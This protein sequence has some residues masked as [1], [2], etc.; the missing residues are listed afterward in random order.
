MN[1][2]VKQILSIAL[3]IILTVFSLLITVSA[4]TGDIYKYGNAYDVRRTPRFPKAGEEVTLEDFDLPI[5][6][7]KENGVNEDGQKEFTYT[8]AEETSGKWSLTS[9]GNYDPNKSYQENSAISVE[10]LVTTFAGRYRNLEGTGLDEDSEVSEFEK[11]RIEI[12][13]LKEDDNHICYGVITS[14]FDDDSILF[15]G[16]SYNEDSG[17]GYYLSNSSYEPTDKK[18]LM[19][20]FDLININKSNEGK[21]EEDKNTDNSSPETND[22]QNNNSS[23]E[24]NNK[25][26][27]NSTEPKETVDI[28]NPNTGDNSNAIFYISLMSISI[29]AFAGIII[30]RKKHS[31]R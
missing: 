9:V 4:K 30:Y 11:K 16:T 29:I 25:Q 28:Y 10:T 21:S 17:A 5:T 2:K 15:F 19:T 27:N 31:I 13:E 12:F 14:Y 3:C 7:V 18:D 20:K 26:D 1:F 8:R 23:P 22:K 6:E 24:I